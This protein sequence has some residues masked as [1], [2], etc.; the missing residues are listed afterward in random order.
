VSRRQEPG[1]QPVPDI[2]RAQPVP[3]IV[4]RTHSRLIFTG[5]HRV[6]KRSENDRVQPTQPT[7]ESLCI[8]GIQR[9]PTLQLGLNRPPEARRSQRSRGRAGRAGR[10]ALDDAAHGCPPFDLWSLATAYVAIMQRA[11]ADEP[12]AVVW[13]RGDPRE[14]G[15]D[16]ILAFSNV[17]ARP[18]TLVART[19][20]LVDER[21]KSSSAPAQALQ[22]FL[23]HSGSPTD[24]D[25][26]AAVVSPPAGFHTGTHLSPCRGHARSA[27][28]SRT[29]HPHGETPAGDADG[30]WSDPRHAVVDVG[31]DRVRGTRQPIPGM[32]CR[33]SICAAHGS[34]PHDV[35]WIVEMQLQRGIQARQGRLSVLDAHR[36]LSDRSRP[37]M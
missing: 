7:R 18:P 36:R 24:V 8:K 37:G 5:T 6:H 21:A 3:H 20:N 14:P 23:E 34:I 35:G 10:G 15:A 11:P 28:P 22:H 1:Q 26:Y 25:A 4:G 29:P 16:D 32:V 33:G 17:A 31:D 30:L 27:S 9:F 19:R 12:P 2:C 13:P